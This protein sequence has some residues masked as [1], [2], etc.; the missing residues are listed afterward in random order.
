LFTRK[1]N[2]IHIEVPVTLVEA[3]LGATIT[4]PT[5]HGAVAVKVPPGSNSGSTLRLKGKGIVGKAAS[6]DQ[7]VRLRVAL[8]DPPDPELVRFLERE[9]YDVSYQ[10]DTDTDRDP[11]SLLHWMQRLIGLKDR[12]DVA[13]ACDPDHDRHGIVT[14]S[15]FNP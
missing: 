13:W 12:F 2:D 1:E 8:P 5:I 11:G 6:G 10:A 14:R 7:Y 15:G 3:V 4:V 9:G